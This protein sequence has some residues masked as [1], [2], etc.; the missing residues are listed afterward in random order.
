M[1]CAADFGFIEGT[2]GE[3]GDP[4]DALI[5]RREPGGDR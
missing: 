5:L 1:G 2:L 4:L 3:D